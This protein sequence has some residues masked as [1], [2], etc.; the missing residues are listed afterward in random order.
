MVIGRALG[1]INLFQ[2]SST[3]IACKETAKSMNKRWDNDLQD[4]KRILDT[5]KC[6]GEWKV[7]CILNTSH[8]ELLN[9]DV[10]KTSE[11][12]SM[13]TKGYKEDVNWARVAR[14]H[15]KAIIRLVTTLPRE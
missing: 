1:L 8:G 9:Q 6:V 5:G 11:L 4:M 7:E 14:K 15:E 2:E 3:K 12:F 10:I 13:R